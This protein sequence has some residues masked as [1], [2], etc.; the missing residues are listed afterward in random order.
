MVQDLMYFR[1]E[2]MDAN[3]KLVGRHI[4]SGVKPTFF[5][6]A[7]LRGIALNEKWFAARRDEAFRLATMHEVKMRSRFFTGAIPSQTG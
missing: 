6:E 7:K 1:P 5:D 2:K 4:G 3:G